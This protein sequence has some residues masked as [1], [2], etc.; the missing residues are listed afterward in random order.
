M[1][2]KESFE[3]KL[4]RWTLNDLL[5]ERTKKKVYS[6]SKLGRI[7]TRIAELQYGGG[8]TPIRA[9]RSELYV[10]MARLDNLKNLRSPQFDLKRV[11]RLCEEINSSWQHGNLMAVGVLTRVLLDHIPPIF[12]H[13]TF[14]QVSANAPRSSKAVFETLEQNSRKISDGLIHQVIRKREILPTEQ[15]VNFSPNL[16]LLLAEAV[17]V[18]EESTS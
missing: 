2:D 12:G 14:A 18:I 16:D 13:T 5:V 15:M 17:R 8:A 4:R 3:D 6:D 10:A 11:V 9:I 7:E 1:A